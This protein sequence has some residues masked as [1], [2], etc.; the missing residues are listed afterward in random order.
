MLTQRL[1]KLRKEKKKTQDDVANF[2][3]IS[4]PAYGNYENGKREPDLETLNKLADYFGVSMDYLVGRSI[5][6]APEEGM[7][8][9]DGG[10]GWTEE[11][12]QMAEA[13]IEAMRKQQG[14]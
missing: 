10:K 12:I 9:S 7:A 1:L 13:I 8:F 4:R 3:G 2:L 6:R 5:A 14:K 11:E